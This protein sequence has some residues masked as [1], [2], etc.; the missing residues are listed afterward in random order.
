VSKKPKKPKMPKAGSPKA[1]AGSKDVITGISFKSASRANSL[2]AIQNDKQYNLTEWNQKLNNLG[3]PS[4]EVSSGTFEYEFGNSHIVSTERIT[5]R[6]GET[7]I[8]RTVYSGSFKY[9]KGIL[10]SADI[11]SLA[12]DRV[13]YDDGAISSRS[14]KIFTKPS[15]VKVMNTS[16]ANDWLSAQT[17]FRSSLSTESYINYINPENSRTSESAIKAVRSF[18]GGNFLY[19]SWWSNPFDSNL[20]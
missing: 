16:N 3:F 15:P 2:E 19:D 4:M 20:I 10:A 1:Q 6:S 9:S 13:S 7:G 8:I 17:Q 12:Q 11:R 18:G 5:D 14:S